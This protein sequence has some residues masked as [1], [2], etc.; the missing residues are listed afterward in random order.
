MI[1]TG[2][3]AIVGKLPV[4]RCLFLHRHPAPKKEVITS[5]SPTAQDAF[6]TVAEAGTCI[7]MRSEVAVA[8]LS[9]ASPVK[10]NWQCLV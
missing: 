3:E 5:L 10:R 7:H 6:S 4:F 8:H 9:L 2:Y 1:S